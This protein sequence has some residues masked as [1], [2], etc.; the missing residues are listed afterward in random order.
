MSNNHT[1]EGELFRTTREPVW[2]RQR[3][4]QPIFEG[5]QVFIRTGIRSHMESGLLRPQVT[6]P[7]HELARY[8]PETV[9]ARV[10]MQDVKND[11]GFHH[12]DP[13]A[14]P[15]FRPGRD[16]IFITMPQTR[17]IYYAMLILKI[18]I[19]SVLPL[20]WVGPALEKGRALEKSSKRS[21]DVPQLRIFGQDIVLVKE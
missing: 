6:I 7:D 9:E 14:P 8:L 4:N 10:L 11:G 1:A 3:I 18:T 21:D 15:I 5:Y 19:K 16:Y 20:E 17:N 13:A 12:Y 2:M